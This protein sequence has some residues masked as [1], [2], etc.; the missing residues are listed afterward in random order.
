MRIVYSLGTA[1]FLAACAG[2]STPPGGTCETRAMTELSALQAAIQT[3]ETSIERGYN[4][5]RR[6]VAD[7]NQIEEVQVSINVA[8]ERQNLANLQS[9]LESTQA[10]ADAAV[11]QCG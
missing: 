3:A 10:Q 7:T 8:K 4:L 6:V 11:A 1:A 9:R 2:S 5:E